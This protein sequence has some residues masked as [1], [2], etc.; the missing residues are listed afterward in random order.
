M[1]TLLAN[2]QGNIDKPP[3]L[4]AVLTNPAFWTFFG[5]AVGAVLTFLFNLLSNR[6]DKLLKERE[7]SFNITQKNI[8]LIKSQY[9]TLNG[10]YVAL[11]TRVT[12]LE[13]ENTILRQHIHK[14]E[15]FLVLKG[16]DIEEIPQLPMNISAQV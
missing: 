11:G 16:I 7:Q 2:L 4:E 6:N 12:K 8:E 5:V 15:I 3:L 13:E 9:E 14:L 10:Q 1:I